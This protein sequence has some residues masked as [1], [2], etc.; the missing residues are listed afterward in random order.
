M[1]YMENKRI[2]KGLESRI[3]RNKVRRN[4]MKCPNCKKA[5]EEWNQGNSWSMEYYYLCK[6]KK[7]LF[8]GIKRYFERKKKPEKEKYEGTLIMVD[9]KNIRK[10]FLLKFKDGKKFEFADSYCKPDYEK[11]KSLENKKVL[12]TI[13]DSHLNSIEEIK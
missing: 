11:I 6:N 3:S 1:D 9:H 7:C 4:K 2:F 13:V 8:F 12:L 5:M 10:F